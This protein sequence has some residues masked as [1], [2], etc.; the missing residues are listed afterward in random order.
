M[1]KIDSKNSI[2]ANTKLKKGI[3]KIYWIR[4]NGK[5]KHI[6]RILGTDKE[7]LLYIGKT[8]GTVRNRLNQFRCTAFLKSTNHSGALKYRTSNA[9]REA[10]NNSELFFVA[11]YC[12]NPSEKEKILIKEYRDL[13]GEVPPLNG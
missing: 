4:N 7:G 10:M 2:D 12:I 3:Y 9:L 1:F 6:S 5:P 11:E 13:Y 8:D